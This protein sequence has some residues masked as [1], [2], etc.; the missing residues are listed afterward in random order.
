MSGFRDFRERIHLASSLLFL[1]PGT[2]IAVAQGGDRDVVGETNSD[3]CSDV[4]EGLRL[5]GSKDETWPVQKVGLGD[6]GGPRAAPRE[7]G[8]A[9]GG[10][11]EGRG[12]L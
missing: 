5:S 1:P 3:S 4:D 9:A 7:T 8:R 6:A 2:A 12:Q 10:G 11:R